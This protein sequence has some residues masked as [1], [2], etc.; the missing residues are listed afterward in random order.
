DL[1]SGQPNDLN[2]SS[3]QTQTGFPGSSSKFAYRL[4][5][6]CAKVHRK[7]V[8]SSLGVGRRRSRARRGFTGR[9]PGVHWEFT[10]RSIDD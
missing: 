8:G 7:D 9:I 6:D 5:G 3:I 4:Y 2:L 10:E 1:F